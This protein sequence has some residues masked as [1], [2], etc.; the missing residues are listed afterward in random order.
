MN[1]VEATRLLRESHPDLRILALSA[2]DENECVFGILKAGASGYVLKEEALDTIVK[3]IRIAYRGETWLSPKVVEKVKRRAIGKEEGVPFTE[4]ELD[5]LRLL[6]KGWTNAR[7]AK[8]L[9]VSERTVRYHL[10]NI[11]DKVGVSTRGQAIV[12]AVRRGF[13]ER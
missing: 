10:R 7:I 11:Y 4:R 3:A 5:V 8:E 12:W 6:A 2:Y 13:G 1:G 9:F